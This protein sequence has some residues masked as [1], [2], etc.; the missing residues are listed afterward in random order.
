MEQSQFKP[1]HE[2]WHH[3]TSTHEMYVWSYQLSNGVDEK[4][5]WAFPEHSIVVHCQQCLGLAICQLL[6]PQWNLHFLVLFFLSCLA[7]EWV[8]K[9]YG[10]V[11]CKKNTFDE[12]EVASTH[13][14]RLHLTK[15]GIKHQQQ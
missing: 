9:C 13:S 10:S 8:N 1:P 2:T 4:R 5:V 11:G 12:A 7:N 14:C 3:I 15:M 6:H